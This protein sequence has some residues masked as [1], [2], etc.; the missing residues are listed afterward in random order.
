[1]A[2]EHLEFLVEERSMKVALTVL[3]KKIV[4]GVPAEIHAFQ[5]KPDLLGKLDRY[6][7]G[8]RHWISDA[9]AAVVVV[10]DRDSENCHELK[11]QLEA[12]AQN[13]GLATPSTRGYEPTRVLN[14][15]AVHELEAWFIG[16]VSALVNAYP[17]VPSTLGQRRGFR[18][19]DSIAHAWERLQTI[20]NE[21]GHHRGG[22]QKLRAAQDIAAYMDVENNR[23]VSF[24]QFRDGLRR[25]VEETAHAA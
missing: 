15:I 24:Q 13:A 6:L 4:P 1:M 16:D 5:G 10:V 20:L 23:S 11:G 3:L 25:L 21:A 14:R 18:D 19:P 2:I 7:A 9:S 17:G 8:Y 12:A 22:L